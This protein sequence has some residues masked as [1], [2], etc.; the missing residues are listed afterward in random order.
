MVFRPYDQAEKFPVRCDLISV[1]KSNLQSHPDEVV[2][3]ASRKLQ[4]IAS[5]IRYQADIF[6]IPE[7]DIETATIEHFP[8]EAGQAQLKEFDLLCK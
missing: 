7:T 3:H 8:L 2:G 6:D 1:G 4:P 5:E